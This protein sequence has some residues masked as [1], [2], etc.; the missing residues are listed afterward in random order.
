[1]H[2]RGRLGSH[3]PLQLSGAHPG[4]ES[5]SRALPWLACPPHLLQASW[6]WLGGWRLR[7]CAVLQVMAVLESAEG[8]PFIYRLPYSLASGKEVSR[9]AD[10]KII[11]II[12]TKWESGNGSFC[13][14]RG[15]SSSERGPRSGL[16]RAPSLHISPTGDS[17]DVGSLPWRK[18]SCS[19]LP[20][21]LC[22]GKPP[23]Y[24]N[25]GRKTIVSHSAQEKGAQTAGTGHPMP[26]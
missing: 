15:Q 23:I 2:Q 19:W 25:L 11:Q 6:L 4:P 10:F 17:L 7:F 8:S 18:A 13:S 14:V 22:T 3:G 9:H 12:N 24:S 5:G 26:N 1:M 20:F 21:D 16:C